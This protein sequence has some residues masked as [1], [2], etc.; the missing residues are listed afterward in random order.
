MNH[1]LPKC[2]LSNSCILENLAF[3][4]F[5]FLPLNSSYNR[6]CLYKWDRDVAYLCSWSAWNNLSLNCKTDCCVMRFLMLKV[7]SVMLENTLSFCIY[8]EEEIKI[9][10]AH[11]M[12]FVTEEWCGMKFKKAWLQ[13]G[14]KRLGSGVPETEHVRERRFLCW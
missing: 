2:K 1:D 12:Q 7:V 5:F 4:F 9:G 3:F 8:A 14:L 6:G 13:N 10:T 11:Q